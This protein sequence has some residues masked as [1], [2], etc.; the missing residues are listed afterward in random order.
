MLRP[1][2]RRVVLSHFVAQ[3]PI[4]ELPLSFFRPVGLDSFADRRVILH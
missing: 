4:V 3:Q 2:L 1:N